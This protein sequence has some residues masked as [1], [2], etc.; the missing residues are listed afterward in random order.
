M[1][2]CRSLRLI[3]ISVI[4][5]DSICIYTYPVFNY[6]VCSRSN[7]ERRQS[8]R[9]RRAPCLILARR[10]SRASV[11]FV[12]APLKPQQAH[13]MRELSYSYTVLPMGLTAIINPTLLG[14]A[15]IQLSSWKNHNICIYICRLS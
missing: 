13:T 15:S 6:V 3:V 9:N 7:S 8:A 12:C 11:M 4:Y 2:D 14:F 5:F 10:I 1:L